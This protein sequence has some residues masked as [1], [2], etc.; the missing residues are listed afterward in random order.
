MG[1]KAGHICTVIG[2]LLILAALAI[3]N[4]NE[5]DADRADYT[6]Q[7]LLTEVTAQQ[8]RTKP[9]TAETAD[10]ESEKSDRFLGT[11]SLPTLNL[12][13][14]VYAT[15]DDSLMKD[16]VCRYAGGVDTENLVIAGH[17]YKRHF[18][19]L[20]NLRIGDEVALTTMDGTTYRYQVEQ[21]ETL[22]STAIDEMTAG[23][24]PLTLF[25]CNYSGQARIAV[26]CQQTS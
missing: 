15:Y 18:G 9:Q 22:D 2:I 19:K 12:E 4:Y 14:P 10:S 11:L 24:Y 21:V 17:N 6:A 8:T 13:L 16:T 20:T 5:W 25:T 3:W 7:T 23:D 1:N 26:C